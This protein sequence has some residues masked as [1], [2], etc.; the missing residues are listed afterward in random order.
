MFHTRNTFTSELS[1]Y[2]QSIQQFYQ[3]LLTCMIH[4]GDYYEESKENSA[5]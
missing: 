3:I 1:L 2:Q 4:I 5:F